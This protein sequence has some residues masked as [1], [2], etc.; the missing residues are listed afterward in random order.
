MILLIVISVFLQFQLRPG[1][2]TA[3]HWS[4]GLAQVCGTSQRL[5]GTWQGQRRSGAD[6]QKWAGRG[7]IT[8]FPQTIPIANLS[9]EFP[10]IVP[11]ESVRKRS[12][13]EVCWRGRV[14]FED[15]VP[16]PE[17]RRVSRQPNKAL[18][19]CRLDPS[20]PSSPP[21]L[22][23]PTEG[24]T[25]NPKVFMD[26]RSG[27]PFLFYFYQLLKVSQQQCPSGSW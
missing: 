10:Q 11:V 22:L 25:Q 26:R 24:N 27:P 17:S 7:E 9:N 5:G 1:L 15:K 16:H 3:S 20:C 18:W 6:G 13:P 12:G 19:I 2:R 23:A 14:A 4:E 8:E 21:D